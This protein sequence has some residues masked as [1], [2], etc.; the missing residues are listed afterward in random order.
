MT[1]DKAAQLDCVYTRHR[2]KVKLAAMR[3]FSGCEG[4]GSRGPRAPRRR[5]DFEQTQSREKIKHIFR[6]GRVDPSSTQ[7]IEDRSERVY[8]Q[9][10]V[11][12]RARRAQRMMMTQFFIALFKM[13]SRQTTH[14]SKEVEAKS[15]AGQP[16]TGVYHRGG[17][18]AVKAAAIL[19][20][21]KIS[22][23]ARRKNGNLEHCWGEWRVVSC[24]VGFGKQPTHACTHKGIHASNCWF[25]GETKPLLCAAVELHTQKGVG[26]CDEGDKWTP[27]TLLSFASNACSRERSSLYSIPKMDRFRRF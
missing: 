18:F 14:N 23:Q 4:D 20:R 2:L 13:N 15:L 25:M 7:S 27:D 6:V 11:S 26:G 3:A 12:E 21:R 17:K 24:R 19:L 9:A 8:A 5:K 16:R 22:S 10:R 1:S